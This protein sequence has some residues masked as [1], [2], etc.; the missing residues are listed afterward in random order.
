MSIQRAAGQK[1]SKVPANTAGGNPNGGEI[2]A[3]MF[4][5]R[6]KRRQGRQEITNQIQSEEHRYM[7]PKTSPI[8]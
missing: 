3:K 2:V 1:E 7:V 5:L 8:P 6:D 4:P